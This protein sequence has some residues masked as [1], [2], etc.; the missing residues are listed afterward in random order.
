VHAQASFLGRQ[1]VLELIELSTVIAQ[2]YDAAIEPA[3]WPPALGSICRYVGGHSGVLFWHDAALESA[4]ALYLFNDDPKFT[5][6]YF[7]KYLPMNPVFPA[8]TFMAEGIVHSTTDFISKDELEQ[9]QFYKEW[10]APQGIA[11]SLA[12]NLE[13]GVARSS[14]INIRMDASLGFENDDA[15]ARMS[16][17][18][19]HLQRAV[20]I[21][22][23]FDQRRATEE[24]LTA[25][26]NHVETA[27]FLVA[28]NGTISFANEP[29][30]KMLNDGNL[31]RKVDQTLRAVAADTDR[32]LRDIF[33]SA[34]D[35]DAAL[36]VGGV[37]VPLTA[38][39]DERWFA[40]VLPLTSGRRQEIGQSSHATAAVFI[41]NTAPNAPP[42]LEAIAKLYKLT[43]GEVRVLNAMLKING[44]KAMADMLGITEGTVRTHLHNLFR[45]T[46]TQRQSDLV[47]LVAGI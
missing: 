3:L 2:I 22:R 7:E 16:L 13:K 9:T 26:I 29:A 23:L 32:M 19:P 37:A 31:V 36:G 10:V 24:A 6:L 46:G 20:S 38:S 39:A 35:G 30:T 45:K 43:A 41:R 47:K 14:L 18:V 40:H 27:V 15:R 11:D 34:A 5:Q 17:L 33:T 42:P 12:V 44:V 4:E 8:A 1:V 21:G 28:A 25:A